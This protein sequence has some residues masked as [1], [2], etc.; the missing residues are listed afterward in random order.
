MSRAHIKKDKRGFN[1]KSST[2]FSYEEEDIFDFQV[3]ISVPLSFAHSV[4]QGP[5]N[6]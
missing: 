5:Q 4:A 6:F 3:C 1:V 2:L